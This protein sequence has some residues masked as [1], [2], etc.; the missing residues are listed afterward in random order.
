MRLYSVC[1]KVKVQ[2]WQQSDVAPSIVGHEIVF[3]YW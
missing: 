3:Y 1:R 2:C